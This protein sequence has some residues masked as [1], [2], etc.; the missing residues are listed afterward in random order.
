MLTVSF[1]IL[2]FFTFEV[3]PAKY[4]G[5]KGFSYEKQ[6]S[7]KS[8][9]VLRAVRMNAGKVS[10]KFYFDS[11]SIMHLLK[12]CGCGYVIPVAKKAFN[13]RNINKKINE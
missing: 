10:N 4:L 7:R 13:L 1:F 9:L 8:I 12:T 5:I 6:N 11:R 2:P 3:H